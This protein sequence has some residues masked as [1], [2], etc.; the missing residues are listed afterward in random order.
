MSNIG[1]E[2]ISND[3][4]EYYVKHGIIHETTTPYSLQSNG[5]AKWKNRTLTDL[6]NAKLDCSGLPNSWLGEAILA[7]CSILNW[8]SSAK[9]DKSRM[10]DGKIESALSVFCVHVVV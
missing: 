10:K 1:G 4:D 6:V 2:Y 8:V 3:F 5:V 7:A 9:G